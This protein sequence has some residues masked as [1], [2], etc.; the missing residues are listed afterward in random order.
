MSIPYY[1]VNAKNGHAY[2]SPTKPMTAIGFHHV[3]LG[4]AGPQAE[5]LARTWNARWYEAKKEDAA[6]LGMRR[7]RVVTK[8]LKGDRKRTGGHYVYFLQAA[9]RVKI[10]T[11]FSP[12]RRAQE[13]AGAAPGRLTRLLIVAGTGTDEK[14]LHARFKAYRTGGE[15]FVASRPLMLTLA[16]CAA[17]GCVVH[18]DAK[19][20]TESE[21]PDRPGV[22]IGS[23]AMA[24]S[25]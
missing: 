2:W 19:P 3:S 4:P 12:L 17:A 14:R 9:D 20:E 18:D 8:T 16:R 25:L 11:S 10:G 1:R 24:N 23:A 5:E 21:K 13:I 6:V 7:V 22:I 15:W